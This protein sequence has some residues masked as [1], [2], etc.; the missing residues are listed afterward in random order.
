[1]HLALDRERTPSDARH[2]T[3]GIEIPTVFEAP[4]P[5]RDCASSVGRIG[6]RERLGGVLSFY[7]RNAA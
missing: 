1:V 2:E 3:A 4:F 6:R 7:D 5:A